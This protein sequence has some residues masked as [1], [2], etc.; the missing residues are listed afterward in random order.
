MVLMG[1]LFALIGYFALA[2][3]VAIVFGR[4]LRTPAEPYVAEPVM[5]YP[6]TRH[7]ASVTG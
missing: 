7:P 1:I 3:P 6:L 4:S 5:A 2:L